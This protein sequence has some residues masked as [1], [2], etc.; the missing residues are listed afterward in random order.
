MD[1]ASRMVA[2]EILV[3]PRNV[4]E[5]KV[6]ALYRSLKKDIPE[7]GLWIEKS[8]PYGGMYTLHFKPKIACF[9]GIL[10]TVIAVGLNVEAN[11]IAEIELGGKGVYN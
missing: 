1:N 6:L 9:N 11:L 10:K 7:A 2:D 3:L 5:N 8:S 4:E